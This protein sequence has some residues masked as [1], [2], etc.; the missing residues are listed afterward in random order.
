MFL[1][2][3]SGREIQAYM[4]RLVEVMGMLTILILVMVSQ[5]STYI[6]TH[7]IMYFKCVQFIVW[8]LCLNKDVF[9]ITYKKK[10][11]TTRFQET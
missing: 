9:K 1:G 6:K 10:I 8:Q 2:A 11:T 4:R 7:Q 5:I 3:G